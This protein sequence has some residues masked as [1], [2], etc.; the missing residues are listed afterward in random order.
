MAPYK[1]TFN[2]LEP[3]SRIPYNRLRFIT[4]HSLYF[5]KLQV[6]II[7]LFDS[8]Y[9]IK[10]IHKKHFLILNLFMMKSSKPLY[11]QYAQNCHNIELA[12]KMMI[13]ID[14]ISFMK[15]LRYTIYR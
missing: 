8:S 14:F 6:D 11:A 12:N 7:I 5:I 10:P 3:F 4:H 2:V 9:C 1:K 13:A 15:I